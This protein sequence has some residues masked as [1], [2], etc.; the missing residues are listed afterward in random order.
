[1][2]TK[3]LN[4]ETEFLELQGQL[5]SYLYRLSANRE[6]AKDIVQDTYV[7]VKEKVSSFKGDSSFKTWCFA[8]ATNLAKDNQR[9]KNRWRLEVQD[10]C[11]N[12][13]LSTPEYQQKIISAFQNQ[14]EQQFEIA[15]H[16]NYC[17]TCIAKNLDLE[18]Q[19]A[20]ILKEIYHF[21]RTEIAKILGKTEGVIKH[22]L[23]NGRKELQT[24]YNKRCSLINKTGVCYQCAE[25][26][27]FLQDEPNSEEK[28]QNLKLN[29]KNN[30]ETNLDI[31]FSI[32]NQINPLNSKASDLED[33]IL[34]IL[35]EVIDDK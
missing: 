28:I 14:T 13:S 1:M 16:I 6:D 31:R 15:E 20:V 35:R 17:F 25:L 18:E 12:A 30:S 22:L 4:I 5:E 27:D 11:K 29:R 32:I 21:K 3:E 23:F 2:Q 26:N 9:V 10:D 7:K 8:I 34:Q 33:T 19:I 24:K